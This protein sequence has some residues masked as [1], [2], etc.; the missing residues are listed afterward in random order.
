MHC[1]PGARFR[2]FSNIRRV[3][4]RSSLSGDCMGIEEHV[5][6]PIVLLVG[7]NMS[8]AFRL[9]EW[10]QRLGSEYHI[11][12]SYQEARILLEKHRF[13][14]VLSETTLPDGN[15]Y[16]LIS[17]LRESPASLLFCLAVEDTYWWLP[18]VTQGRDCLGVPVLRPAEFARLLQGTLFLA[19]LRQ[20]ASRC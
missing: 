1:L 9:L 11:T 14:V 13:D 6:E 8:G 4:D 18:A 2:R 20:T 16:R 10:L 3:G 15:A 12:A 5:E 7:K 17:A 19:R